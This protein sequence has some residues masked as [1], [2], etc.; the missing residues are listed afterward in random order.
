[1][2]ERGRGFDDSSMRQD[3]YLH[4][5]GT[6]AHDATTNWIRVRENKKKYNLMF[7]E[8]LQE[9]DF[10]ISPRITFEVSVKVLGGLMAL[11]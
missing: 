9:G 1:M 10:I 11:G 4:P 2:N 5:P 3:I 6:L 7:S 8:W